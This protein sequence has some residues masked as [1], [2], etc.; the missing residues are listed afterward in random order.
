MGSNAEAYDKGYL[1]RTPIPG[2]LEE[3]VENVE[4]AGQTSKR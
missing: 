3:R 2:I 4:S 1:E